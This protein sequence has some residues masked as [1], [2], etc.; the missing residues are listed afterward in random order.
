LYIAIVW[1]LAELARGRPR[2]R[3]ALGAAAVAVVAVLAVLTVRQTRVWR[4]SITLFRHSL[5][6]EES[7]LPHAAPAD[8]PAAAG[9]RGRAY[10][11]YRAALRVQPMNP[12]GWAGLGIALQ[13][14]GRPREAVA[15]LE[16]SVRLD[17]EA[18]IPRVVLAVALSNLGDDDRAGA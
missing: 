11:E 9:G 14:W 18:E 1:G 6:V 10:A 17:P 13:S 3:V 7:Y 15:C 12:R 4:N 5:A 8:A 2:L 16:R